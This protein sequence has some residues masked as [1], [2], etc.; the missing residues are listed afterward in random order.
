[1]SA[2]PK[3][4]AP[5]LADDPAGKAELVRDYERQTIGSEN[6]HK[7]PFLPLIHTDGI[8][9]LAETCGA[10]WL[11]DAIASYQTSARV[12]RESFQVWRLRAPAKD[13]DP[14][15][16]DCWDD[17]PEDKSPTT[18]SRRLVSQKIPYSDFPRELCPFECWVESGT[19]MLKAER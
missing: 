7:H 4:I 19:L 15:I 17:T 13:E 6:M 5:L 11:I 2:T 9:F 14:W 18:N 10:Y 1:M 3:R 16:L 8:E 12:R